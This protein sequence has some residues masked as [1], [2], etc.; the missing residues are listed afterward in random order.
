MW[1]HDDEVVL[2]TL[3][4]KSRHGISILVPDDI[5]FA[6]GPHVFIDFEGAH[7]RATVAHLTRAADGNF[8]LGLTWS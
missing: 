7:R 8:Q 5:D 1:T 2:V 3:G 6:L 4:D